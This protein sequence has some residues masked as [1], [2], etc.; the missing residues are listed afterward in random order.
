MENLVFGNVVE[1]TI[2]GDPTRVV[3]F[4]PNSIET[5]NKLYELGRLAAQKETEMN[6]KAKEIEA[7]DG[8]TED[9]F[10]KSAE[11]GLSFMK[12]VASSF[13]SEIDCV[14][15]EGTSEKV[16]RYGFDFESFIVFLEFVTSKMQDFSG[17][18]IKSRLQKKIAKTKTM[19]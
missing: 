2:D 8:E 16:F 5:R 9:G 10:P 13:M 12:E 3:R 15:G 4:N 19:K 1:F 18:K 6:A 11:A 7:L 14:F 17:E